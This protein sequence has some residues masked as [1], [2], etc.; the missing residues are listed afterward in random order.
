MVVYPI[1]GCMTIVFQIKS[2]ITTWAFEKVYS[3][4]LWTFK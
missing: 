3:L 1:T 4:L 2:W